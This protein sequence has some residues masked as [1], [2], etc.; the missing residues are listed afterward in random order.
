MD[1]RNAEHFNE[2][3]NDEQVKNLLHKFGEHFIEV[4]DGDKEATHVQ[5]FP[6]KELKVVDMED[7]YRD[8][9][10]E[11][12]DYQDQGGDDDMGRIGVLY[13]GIVPLAIPVKLEFNGEIPMIDCEQFILGVVRETQKCIERIFELT[14]PQEGIIPEL[15]A[16]LLEGSDVYYNGRTTLRVMIQFPLLRTDFENIVE[17]I[18]PML[19]SRVRENN[20]L[21]LLEANLRDILTI[22]WNEIINIEEIDSP[23]PLYLSI[24]DNLYS[25]LELSRIFPKLP[26]DLNHN[27]DDDLG[28]NFL[29]DPA[30]HQFF[31]LQENET[32]NGLNHYYPLLFDIHYYDH[33]TPLIPE[34]EV[35]P[36]TP[37][38]A[39]IKDELKDGK[40][41]RGRELE[42]AKEMIVILMERPNILE[43][44]SEL[45]GKSIHGSDVQ[46]NG[47]ATQEGEELFM[48]VKRIAEG[49]NFCKRRARVEYKYLRREK[50]VYTYKTI[51]YITQ[52]KMPEEFSKWHKVWVAKAIQECLAKTDEPTKLAEVIYREF[53]MT[54]LVAS[55]AKDHWYMF[56]GNAWE[57][58]DKS[59]EIRDSILN[60][61]VPRFE[62]MVVELNRQRDE[63]NDARR[64][65]DYATDIQTVEKILKYLNS[66]R[67]LNEIV[68]TLRIKFYVKNF[69]EKQNEN[70]YVMAVRNGVLEA[71]KDKVIFRS[72]FPEDYI[73]KKADAFYEKHSWKH[74]NVVFLMN[75]F[76]QM[77]PKNTAH[78]FLKYA[79]S[80]FIG[81]NIDKI[82]IL[83][84]GKGHNA[85]SKINFLFQVTFGDDYFT[86]IAAEAFTRKKNSASGPTQEW[87]DARHSRVLV[88]N[89][90]TEDFY[91][92]MLKKITGADRF[93]SRGLNEKGGMMNPTFKIMIFA[94]KPPGL[95]G[96]YAMQERVRPIECLAQY[97]PENMVPKTKEEQIRQRKFPMDKNI[98]EKLAECNDAFLWI[99]TEYYEIYK[100]EGLE[101]PKE[102]EKSAEK[103]WNKYDYIQQFINEYI[104]K[105]DIEGKPI[106]ETTKLS[107]NE[108]YKHFTSWYIDIHPNKKI[109]D[110]NDF[111]YNLGQKGYKFDDKE[112]YCLGIRN[113]KITGLSG[114]LEGLEAL[115]PD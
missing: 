69:T 14:P 36:K 49:D 103:Y 13:K 115:V 37:M 1:R 2:G 72:G 66:T 5:F 78:F 35:M 64:R 63:E 38:H 32:L 27:E 97:L 46:E 25:P 67:G 91:S 39:K 83:F 4:E 114:G 101:I 44:Y 33:K 85:K 19:Q 107:I 45:I 106:P 104:S 62:K 81:K 7:F 52:L 21:D 96:D 3:K 24:K 61:I 100:K 43:Y 90:P 8:Y 6:Y 50:L 80:S 94:N 87:E 95:E 110:V 20:I 47:K 93:R 16:C 102:M 88:I 59:V 84:T 79:S 109:P 92:D 31:H 105:E 11:M 58:S 113:K 98:D 18:Y 34:V 74:P 26:D 42:I 111:S 48:S 75:W 9:C 15:V 82:F 56:D 41:G 71:R 73:T 112:A 23:L 55:Y 60:K 53:F 108:I 70:I 76:H 65:K 28:V 10:D 30:K 54:F 29:L 51:C 77:W 99:L 40:A 89:E 86:D 12:V 22:S 17:K 57:E 68:T